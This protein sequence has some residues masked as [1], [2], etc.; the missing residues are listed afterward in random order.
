MSEERRD[1]SSWYERLIF[2]E[3]TQNWGRSLI[4]LWAKS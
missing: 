2:S 3:K 1:L 4:T